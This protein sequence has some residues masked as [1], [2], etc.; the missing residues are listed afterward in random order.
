MV[1]FSRI[2]SYVFINQGK[3]VRHLNMHDK[4]T[5]ALIQQSLIPHLLVYPPQE[6]IDEMRDEECES[7]RVCVSVHF[8]CDS[9][10]CV[11]CVYLC[12]LCVSK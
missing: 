9:Y 7:L 3:I 6:R 10:A 4:A 5:L 1:Q 12:P 8:M 2:L 11:P